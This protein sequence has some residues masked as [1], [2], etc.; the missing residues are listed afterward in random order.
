VTE[1]NNTRWVAPEVMQSNELSKASDVYSFGMVMYE[2]LTWRLPYHTI[3]SIVVGVRVSGWGRG[4]QVGRGGEW[5]GA[6]QFQRRWMDCVQTD[7]SLESQRE[8]VVESN[9]PGSEWRA[10]RLHQTVRTYVS[11]HT[12]ISSPTRSSLTHP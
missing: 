1:H 8:G 7:G 3:P 12:C 10:V 9:E 4:G 11:I 2:A 6:Q 5:L